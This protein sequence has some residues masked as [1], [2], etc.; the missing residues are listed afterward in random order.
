[1]SREAKAW[2]WTQDREFEAAGTE[3]NLRSAMG[4][5]FSLVPEIE[6]SGMLGNS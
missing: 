6:N 2:Q 4:W 1:M 3:G 5:Y